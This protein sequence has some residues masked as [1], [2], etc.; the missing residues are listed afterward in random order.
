MNSRP[1]K[2][3]ATKAHRKPARGVR[4]APASARTGD[5]KSCR[6]PRPSTRGKGLKAARRRRESRE[7][8][9][10]LPT[11][12]E[13][14]TMLTPEWVAEGV[15]QE[16]ERFLNT[17]LQAGFVERLAARTYYLYPRNK[18]FHKGLNRSGNGGRET[19]RM[20]MRHWMAGWLHRECPLLYKRLPYSFAN[21]LPLPD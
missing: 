8:H 13:R 4:A 3:P 21:G 7:L 12:L 20:F 17:N 9:D 15:V 2:S 1:K 10:L 6:Q 14:D 16:V 18:Q 5:V 11:Q 19:L